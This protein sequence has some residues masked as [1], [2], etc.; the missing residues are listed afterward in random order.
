[1]ARHRGE[2]DETRAS[3]RRCGTES[4]S[5]LAATASDG[6]VGTRA[7]QARPPTPVWWSLVLDGE[8]SLV[9]E[10]GAVPYRLLLR[11]TS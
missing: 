1:M 11:M 10:L 2:A 3:E 8:E 4:E 9:T 7:G 6:G 5:A